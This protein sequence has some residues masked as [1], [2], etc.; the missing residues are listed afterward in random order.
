MDA[1]TLTIGGL[2][3]WGW[4]TRAGSGSLPPTGITPSGTLPSLIPPTGSGVLPGVPGTGSA[5]GGA[6]GGGTESGGPVSTLF[7]PK[8]IL[9]LSET[10]LKQMDQLL[11]SPPGTFQMSPEVRAEWELYRAGEQADYTDWLASAPVSDFSFPDLTIGSTAL[12]APE[13][14]AGY[15]DPTGYTLGV[16]TSFQSAADF[17]TALT[18]EFA[19]MTPG[20]AQEFVVSLAA[21]T[22]Q[23]VNFVLAGLGV[24]GLL[25]GALSIYQGVQQDSGGAIA[26]GVLS[27]AVGLTTL[28]AS[29]ALGAS[30]AAISGTVG[31]ALGVA[32]LPVMVFA[33]ALPGGLGDMQKDAEQ[34]VNQMRE[35]QGILSDMAV[36]WPQMVQGHRAALA[37]TLV[38]S[39][40]GREAQIAALR[41]IFSACRIGLAGGAAVSRFLSTGGGRQSF[42]PGVDTSSYEAVS[43][44]YSDDNIIGCMRAEEAL[45]RLG[46]MVEPG[47]YPFGILSPTQLLDWFAW[48]TGTFVTLPELDEF[49]NQAK[50]VPSGALLDPIVPSLVAGKS[51]SGFWAAFWRGNEE[52]MV[53]AVVR[54]YNPTGWRTTRFGQRL[55]LLG[56]YPVPLAPVEEATRRAEYEYWMDIFNNT[57]QGYLV[58]ETWAN[59]PK[60]TWTTPV[61]IPSYQ[62]P[63]ALSYSYTGGNGA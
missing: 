24:L 41:R 14:P 18:Q 20:E 6:G 43:G 53:M 56:T 32:A 63:T 22:G 42:F 27:T 45:I 46:V 48:G 49:G 7:S 8:M 2:L 39:I 30:A 21:T 59:A 57:N 38:P 19:T 54:Y 10:A 55:Q 15:I 52:E 62:D 4:L 11:S 3:L 26:L 60:L 58:P 23:S 12:F 47:F 29:G 34:L 51:G 44:T 28:A 61:F 40:P 36:A 13:I 17:H 50:V 37:L 31:A 9:K 16:D 25:T 33:W 35:T 1:A 5:P